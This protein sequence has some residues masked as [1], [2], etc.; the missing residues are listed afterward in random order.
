MQKPLTK[1]EEPQTSSRTVNMNMGFSGATNGSRYSYHHHES[2]RALLHAWSVVSGT[3]MV[4]WRI[5]GMSSMS[6]AILL[7]T[8]LKVVV[9]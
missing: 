9:A 5:C 4:L 1:V 8:N 3:K 2:C 6:I 7:S